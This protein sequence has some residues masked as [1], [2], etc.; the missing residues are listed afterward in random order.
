MKKRLLYMSFL[1]FA[2]SFVG[3]DANK[4]EEPKVEKQEAEKKRIR[5][6]KRL[7]N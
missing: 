7:R 6:I 1:L 5:I 2:F 3:C 4:K